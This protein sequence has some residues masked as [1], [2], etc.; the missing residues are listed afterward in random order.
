MRLV[1]RQG[2]VEAPHFPFFACPDKGKAVALTEHRLHTGH[3]ARW[4]GHSGK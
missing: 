4:L 3:H 2:G 1:L